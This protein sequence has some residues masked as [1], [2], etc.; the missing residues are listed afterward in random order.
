MTISFPSKM[1]SLS[2]MSK[3]VEE[4]KANNKENARN[5]KR[6]AHNERDVRENRDRGGSDRWAER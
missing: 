1:R 2:T 5:L 3:L 6:D 4:P